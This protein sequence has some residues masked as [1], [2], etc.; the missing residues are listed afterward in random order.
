[1][2]YRVKIT[3]SVNEIG[4]K[5]TPEIKKD[6]KKVLNEFAKNP[7][8]GKELQ[9]ELSGFRSYRFLRY[10]IVYKIN[11][12]DKVVVVWAISHR[13][14]IYENLAEYLIKKQ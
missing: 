4:K 10:R 7:H 2:H 9:R 3:R 6:A 12:D 1:M 8:I 11:T 14:D 5:L 13:S